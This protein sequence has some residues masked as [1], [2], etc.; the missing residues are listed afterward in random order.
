MSL[1][2]R[3][4]RIVL[5]GPECTGKTTLAGELARR[6]SLPVSE[7]AARQLAAERGPLTARDIHEVARLEIELEDLAE[8]RARLLGA[9]AVLHDTDLVS[10]VAYGR[11]FYG[12][13]PEW[14]ERAARTRRADL[15]LLL[16]PDLPFLP[17]PD[18]RG[19][20]DERPAQLQMFEQVLAE[21]AIRPVAVSGRDGTRLLEAEAAIRR[22]LET[23][24]GRS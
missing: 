17:E 11:F 24:A 5:T 23:P 10:T 14:I 21:L 7:E 16:L 18:Q 3:P 13:C 20:Q 12:A 2:E 19:E 9:P 1:P 4:L 22:L 8:T 6:L 15:Y